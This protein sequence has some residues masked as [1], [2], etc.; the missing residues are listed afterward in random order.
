MLHPGTIRPLVDA[1]ACSPFVVDWRHHNLRVDF[2]NYARHRHIRPREGLRDGG[3]KATKVDC[4]LQLAVPRR[5][6]V[7]RHECV[8]A[9][10]TWLLFPR[11]KGLCIPSRAIRRPAHLHWLRPV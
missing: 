11:R 4:A 9:D 2:H 1:T 7:K 8:A 5:D 3:G 10:E 6:S